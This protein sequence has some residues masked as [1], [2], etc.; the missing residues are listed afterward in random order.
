MVGQFIPVVDKYIKNMP[1]KKPVKIVI[2]TI[3]FF[4]RIVIIRDDCIYSKTVFVTT[5]PIL[6]A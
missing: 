5:Q 4:Y 6:L 3:S 1:V 2:A